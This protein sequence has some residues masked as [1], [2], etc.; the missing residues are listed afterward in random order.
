MVL[1]K[2]NEMLAYAPTNFLLQKI[3]KKIHV[4][5]SNCNNHLA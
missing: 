1:D 4:F 3:Q 5:K 2:K